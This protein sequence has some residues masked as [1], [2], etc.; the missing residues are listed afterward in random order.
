M[1]RVEV[2]KLMDYSGA[3]AANNSMADIFS[4]MANRN[5]NKK[6]LKENKRQHMSDEAFRMFELN[7]KKE[8]SKWEQLFKENKF[9]AQQ[10]EKQNKRT[11]NAT[12][13]KTL[14]P[15][16]T[17]EIGQAFGQVPSVTNA[18]KMDNVLGNM[19]IGS[20]ETKN[21]FGFDL[22]KYESSVAI[23]K[24]DYKYK[25]GQD[26]ISNKQN[27]E[28]ID[29][30]RSVANRPKN[31]QELLLK[32]APSLTKGQ[33]PSA[34]NTSE[35]NMQ[36][37]IGN[38]NNTPLAENSNKQVK[39]NKYFNQT[40]NKP[41]TKLDLVTKKFETTYT[42]SAGRTWGKNSVTGREYL[43]KDKD[44]TSKTKEFLTN[45]LS[46]DL[47]SLQYL[48]ENHNDRFTGID[49]LYQDANSSQFSPFDEDEE[50]G[51]YKQKMNGLANL[52][53]NK[54]FGA[55]L[56]DGEKQA[57]KDGYVALSDRDGS[58]VA[59]IKELNRIAKTA[60]KRNY[61]TLVLKW[62]ENKVNKLYEANGL[63]SYIGIKSKKSW[64]DY[65]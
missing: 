10:T 31:L 63:S 56:T 61:N 23:D 53:R 48:E 55:S 18:N 17:S 27:Q 14:Y 57:F 21:R 59:K 3:I 12:A 13:I 44:F 64:K 37:N 9:E 1:S 15:K 8:E 4:G 43:L 16:V 47:E 35:S 29:I 24:R 2:P 54:L 28:K 19:D 22:N 62:G 60:L 20:I 5:Q 7:S 52:I 39:E 46:R 32:I 51:V 33:A 45:E 49:T 34:T 65:E 41:I 25:A 50:Y 38:N 26:K 40:E 11:A 58:F 6:V 30:S 42:D 36:N